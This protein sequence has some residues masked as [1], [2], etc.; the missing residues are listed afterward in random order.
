MQKFDYKTTC[1]DAIYAK[2]SHTLSAPNTCA[3]ALPAFRA[4]ALAHPLCPP[5]ARR[6]A[7]L[8]SCA[9]AVALV[10]RSS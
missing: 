6:V 1:R 3:R 7:S 4:C 5:R 9:L 8:P 10:S 2:I